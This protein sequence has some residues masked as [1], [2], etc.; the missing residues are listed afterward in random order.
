MNNEKYI[1]RFFV[2]HSVPN[3]NTQW[4]F[5]LKILNTYS[6]QLSEII[7]LEYVIVFKHFFVI[8]FL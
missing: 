4:G 1:E 2:A 3:K 8:S 7:T 6:T 5:G